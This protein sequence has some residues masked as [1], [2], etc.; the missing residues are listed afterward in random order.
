VGSIAEQDGTVGAPRREVG[1][2]PDGV[3]AISGRGFD[4]MPY[5]GVMAVSVTIMQLSS[6]FVSVHDVAL[7]DARTAPIRPPSYGS[8]ILR[9]S[10]TV[11]K[12]A[13]RAK[14]ENNLALTLKAG[15]ETIHLQEPADAAESP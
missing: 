5:Y 12:G 11:T 6:D 3:D 7:R 2:R 4:D 8:L 9:R 10:Q 13:S 1:S 15:R 14:R